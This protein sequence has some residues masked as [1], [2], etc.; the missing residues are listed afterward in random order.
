M[1][2]ILL[3]YVPQ[4][5]TTGNRYCMLLIPIEF[6]PVLRNVIPESAAVSQ[7][8]YFENMNC[9]YN[10]I[11]TSEELILNQALSYLDFGWFHSFVVRGI[12]ALCKSIAFSSLPAGLCWHGGSLLTFLPDSSFHPYASALKLCNLELFYDHGLHSRRGFLELG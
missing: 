7:I 11:T 3:S 12:L 2:R 10:L 1:E 8:I 5:L 6:L 4:K 9:D